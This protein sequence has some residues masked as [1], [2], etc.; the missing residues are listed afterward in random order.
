MRN[1]LLDVTTKNICYG[2][3]IMTEEKEVLIRQ[4]KWNGRRVVLLYWFAIVFVGTAAA[5]GLGAGVL[6][7]KYTFNKYDHSGISDPWHPEDC[8]E[9]HEEE[10]LGWNETLHSRLLTPYNETHLVHWNGDYYSYDYIL[11]DSE[12]CCHVTRWENDTS[13]IPSG[14]GTVWDFGVACAECHKTPGTKWPTGYPPFFPANDPCGM[15]CHMPAGVTFTDM[16]ASAHAESLDDLLASDHAASRCLHCMAGQGLYTD[17]SE[18]PVNDSSLFNI[19]CF[20]CHDPHA[21]SK[22]VTYKDNKANLRGDSIPELCGECHGTPYEMIT[23]TTTPTTI[24][25]STDCTDCHGYYFTPAGERAGRFGTSWQNA[26]FSLNHSFAISV[27]DACARCH[28]D[29]YFNQTTMPDVS[30]RTDYLEDVQT[31]VADLLSSFDTKLTAV[32]AK[33]DEARAVSGVDKD[34]I[35]HID[36]LIEEAEALAEFVA[37]DP[38]GGFHNPDL[39]KQKLALA[40]SKLDWA[41]I[42]AEALLAEETSE[43]TESSEAPD[44]A[45][46]P[47]IGLLAVLSILGVVVLLRKRR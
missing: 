23:D 3:I 44:G 4:S 33:A 7:P 21:V 17:L 36:A 15:T 6:N 16:A 40:L 47:A 39:A 11:N 41:Q 2:G 32:K 26:S 42:A 37:D 30:D 9:C 22:T 13:V 28:W 46:T 19:Q 24:T 12:G 43:T 8:M 18:T 5:A 35:A 14:N 25:N 29:F 10:Y 34:E 1:Q 31:E 20:T 38:S 45:G 27:P